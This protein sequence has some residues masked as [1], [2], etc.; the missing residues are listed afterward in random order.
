MMNW[1][2]RTFF[3]LLLF[4]SVHSS[5]ITASSRSKHALSKRE[6][7]VSVSLNGHF[8]NQLFQIA[9]AYAYSLDHGI[10]LTI[11]DLVLNP[12]F[13]IP[14]NA[15]T[16]FLR[17]IACYSPHLPP[18]LIW[19][20]PNFNYS[21]IPVF[22][23]IHLKG[24]FQSDKYFAHRRKELLELFAA[25]QGHNERIL[26]KYPFLASDALVVGIQIRDYRAYTPSGAYHP[27]LK[28]EYYQKALSLFPENAIFV[29]TSN[30]LAFAKEC[31]EGSGR[32][33]IY[34]N[35]KIFF[36]ANFANF[37]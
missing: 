35:T 12:D 33:I 17:H 37:P 32:T 3:C 19:Q 36:S 22:S 16:L 24:Y 7:Y 11:P 14:H 18:S 4:G 8:G 29:V 31:V 5:N 30:N 20:E 15:K 25:P 13:N 28:R 9:T 34:L 21:P 1:F 10:A 23:R 26:A 2:I 27:T 6:K